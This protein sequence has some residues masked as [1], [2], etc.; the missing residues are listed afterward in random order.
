MT[1]S[2]GTTVLSTISAPAAAEAPAEAPALAPVPD[3]GAAGG[4]LASPESV[5]EEPKVD[6]NLE[7]SRKF[8]KAARME[9][10]ARKFEAEIQQTRTQVQADAKRF[11]DMIK[12]FEED[13]IA[14]MQAN[15]K[16]PVEF[17]KR[18]TAPVSEEQRRLNALEERLAAE[19]KAKTEREEQQAQEARKQQQSQVFKNFVERTDPEKYPHMTARWEPS[20]LHGAIGSLLNSPHDASDP[21]SP[22]TLEVF[23]SKYGR[24]PNDEE[25]REALEAQAET[26]ATNLIA[27]VSARKPPPLAVQTGPSA[28]GLSSQHAAQSSG[29]STRTKSREE[30]MRALRE[31]AEAERAK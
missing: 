19:E 3:S 11:A 16:D 8:D 21:R 23:R 29:G 14:W 22:T 28:T 17:V 1:M 5:T 4:E 6:P 25:I 31:Q 2:A 9:A 27:K 18:I 20:E 7:L 10:K 24:A 13:P 30:T 12:Q 15:K 26:Y